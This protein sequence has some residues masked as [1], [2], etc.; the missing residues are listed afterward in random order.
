MRERIRRSTSV[1][2]LYEA[3]LSIEASYALPQAQLEAR[4]N[5]IS[6][7]LNLARISAKVVLR[8]YNMIHTFLIVVVLARP[9]YDTLTQRDFVQAGRNG[10]EPLRHTWYS[11]TDGGDRSSN[12]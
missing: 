4:Y 3:R 6:V 12:K 10:F 11:R 9:I 8:P 2:A 1:K 5:D 7:L